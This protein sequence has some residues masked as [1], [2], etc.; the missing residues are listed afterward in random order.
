MDNYAYFL[1]FVEWQEQWSPRA[2]H[3]K[4]L[5]MGFCQDFSS[6]TIVFWLGKLKKPAKKR[7]QEPLIIQD[8]L[9]KGCSI[10][11]PALSLTL[12]DRVQEAVI[13]F[14]TACAKMQS[15]NY[16]Q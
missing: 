8:P 15:L 14:L 1:G 7:A 12:L 13:N 2:I 11:K 16:P 10:I 9:T 5:S 6:I 4:N 3:W